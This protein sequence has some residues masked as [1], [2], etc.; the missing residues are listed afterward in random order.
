MWYVMSQWKANSPVFRAVI[1]ERFGDGEWAWFLEII[2]DYVR[3]NVVRDADGMLEL[4]P[5]GTALLEWLLRDTIQK[6]FIM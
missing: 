5:A 3:W 4:T 6:A 2:G 1:A